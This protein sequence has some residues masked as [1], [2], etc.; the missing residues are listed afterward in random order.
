LTC[1]QACPLL[2][3]AVMEQM[4]NT[5]LIEEQSITTRGDN[6]ISVTTDNSLSSVHTLIQIQCGDHKGLLYDIMRT[7]KDC[8]IQISYGRFYATQN[9]RCDVD[10]FVVQSDGKKI[11]DQQRQRSLCCRLRMELLRPLRVALV[12]R[13]PDTELL[14][15]NP[16]EVSGKGRPLVFYDITLA[17]KNLQKR[18][19]LAEIGRQVVE[20]REWEVYRVHFGEEHDLSAALQS[21]IVGGVTSMLMG[22]D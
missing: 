8:N 20:D 21:K 10:L 9:G 1:L 14:V 15:A 5:D 22:W 16:V 7:V 13:G 2:T 19:F 12:N 18:I 3:P 6:A 4:F 11:L 17:L